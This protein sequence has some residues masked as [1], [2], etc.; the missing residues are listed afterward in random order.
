LRQY[1]EDYTSGN[2]RLAQASS[3]FLFF[4]SQQVASAGLGLGAAVRW[5][6]DT[7]QKAWGGTPYPARTGMIPTGAPT[8]SVKLNL[9]KGELVQVRGYREILETVDEGS[10]NRG[11]SFDPE[12][13]PYCGGRYRVLD[14]VDQII[15]EKTGKMMRLRKD[16]IMLEGVV[17]RA[18]YSKYRRFCPRS[19]YP[20]WREIWLERVGHDDRFGAS[21]K[22]RT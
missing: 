17:C 8:P 5:T 20:Y 9:K 3:A 22:T 2:V 13:V 6:Y 21:E 1:L 16:C 12:M 7:I 18:C 4:L 14:R 11:M 15:N 19:I 10:F